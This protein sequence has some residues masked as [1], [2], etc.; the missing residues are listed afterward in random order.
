MIIMHIQTWKSGF[1][2]SAE[3]RGKELKLHIR[4]AKDADSKITLLIRAGKSLII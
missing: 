3:A 4:N 2:L 1:S